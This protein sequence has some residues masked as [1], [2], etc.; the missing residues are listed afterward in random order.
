MG[1]QDLLQKP[2]ETAILPWLGGRELR[3]GPRAWSIQGRFPKEHGWYAFKLQGRKAILDP[4][5][6]AEITEGGAPVELGHQVT[7]YLVGDRLVEDQARV[8][9]NPAHVSEVAEPVFLIEPG[10]DRFVHV[11]AGRACEDGPL[12]Y[13]GITMPLGQEEEVLQA[14][15]DEKTSVSHLKGVSPALDAAFRMEV[16]QKIEAAK[17][18]AE[19]ERIRKEEE[20]KRAIEERRKKLVEQLGD[21]AGRRAM[22]AIDFNEAA[23]AA[24][25]IGGVEFLDSRASVRKGEMVVKFRLDGRR[26]ECTCE[27]HSLRVID[28][29][30]CLVDHRTNEKGDNYFT[31]ESLPAVIRQAQRE[32]KLVVFRRV[33]QDYGERRFDDDNGDN[34]DYDD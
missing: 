34:D 5:K 14:F 9:P 12:I 10:L 11:S 19:L 21:G 33:D 4:A 20:A 1:W 15:L 26:F 8:D 18:R 22:A 27:K 28:A 31:L 3:S 23:R 17:R 29:G 7:G 2:D 24:F 13:K 30:I 25:A 32:G 16:W 6:S